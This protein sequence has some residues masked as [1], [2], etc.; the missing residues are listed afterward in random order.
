MP[1]HRTVSTITKHQTQSIHQ[2]GFAGTG[3]TGQRGHTGRQFGLDLVD[4][5]QVTNVYMCEH[6]D[7]A[8]PSGLLTPAQFFPQHGKVVM[9]LR[10]EQAQGMIVLANGDEVIGFK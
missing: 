6:I 5:R 3:F 4:Y 9:F 8:A 2:D 1:Y 10:V 7:G